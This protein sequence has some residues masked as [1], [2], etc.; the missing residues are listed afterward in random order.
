MTRWSR[1]TPHRRNR[2]WIPPNAKLKRWRSFSEDKPASLGDRLGDGQLPPLPLS[3]VGLLDLAF[4]NFYAV[5]LQD[6][7]VIA[8][9]ETRHH[10]LFVLRARSEGASCRE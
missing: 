10:R 3:I 1:A 2:T 4:Q 6:E 5:I 9:G 7:R 8:G